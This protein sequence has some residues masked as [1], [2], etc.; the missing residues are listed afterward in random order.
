MPTINV[1][2]SNSSQ[3]KQVEDII[4]EL[5]KKV[6]EELSNSD[7]QLGT[8]E[9]SIRLIQTQGSGML[10]SLELEIT[11]HAFEERVQRQDEICLHIREF[12]KQ[13]VEANEVR[14]WLLLPEL[15]HSWE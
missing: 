5:K 2:S 11:A 9:V 10:A 13:R 4:P 1:F 15:G 8:D 6:A 7:I 12:L 3:L 14:V